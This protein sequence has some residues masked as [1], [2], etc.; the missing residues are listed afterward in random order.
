MMTHAGNPSFIVATKP[1]PPIN[2]SVAKMPVAIIVFFR[3][4]GSGL[5]K[6]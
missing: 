4:F 5:A 6:A 3:F 2:I 1:N